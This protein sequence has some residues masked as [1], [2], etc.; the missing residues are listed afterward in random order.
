MFKEVGDAAAGRNK[1]LRILM[2]VAR[3]ESSTKPKPLAAPWSSEVKGLN[4]R[5]SSH[6]GQKCEVSRKRAFKES[7]EAFDQG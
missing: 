6:H 3:F 4:K 2:V 5:A 1:H 7:R